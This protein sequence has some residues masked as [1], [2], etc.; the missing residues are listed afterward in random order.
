MKN[1]E[2]IGKYIT[3]FISNA[4]KEDMPYRWMF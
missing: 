3:L 2:L 1:G 4:G